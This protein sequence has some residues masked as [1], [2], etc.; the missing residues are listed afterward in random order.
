LALHLGAVAD[1]TGGQE[2][3]TTNL[4]YNSR[5]R[6]IQAFCGLNSGELQSQ[7]NGL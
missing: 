7:E 4:Y 2:R 5:D 6:Q 1:F 3:L